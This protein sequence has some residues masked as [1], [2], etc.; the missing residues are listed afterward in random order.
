MSKR[1]RTDDPYA[2]AWDGYIPGTTPVVLIHYTVAVN[3]ERV[4]EVLSENKERVETTLRMMPMAAMPPRT[5]R[6]Y[7]I[8]QEGDICYYFGDWFSNPREREEIRDAL[9]EMLKS[10]RPLYLPVNI[11]DTLTI[12]DNSDDKA[13]V[14]FGPKIL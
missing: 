2:T 10:A 7:R 4:R 9:N 6:L 14:S 11:A 12:Y 1:Q 13:D 8:F 3:A 5:A